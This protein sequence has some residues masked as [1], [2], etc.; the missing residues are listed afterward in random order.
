VP[1]YKSAVVVLFA[2]T[3]AGLPAFGLPASPSD[4][5]YLREIQAEGSR[6]TPL[7]RARE[8][9][10]EGEARE[11]SSGGGGGARNNVDLATFE[12]LLN[13]DAPASFSLYNRLRSEQKLD[14]Y[15]T[16]RKSGKLSDAKRRI[17][18]TFLGI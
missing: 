12:K 14:I 15:A 8:E 6:L 4:D 11:K 10:R 3:V 1:K 9:I 13:S 7:D 16:Y 18:D 5:A 2:V 17:V